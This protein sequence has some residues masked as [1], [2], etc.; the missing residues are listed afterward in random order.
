MIERPL[1]RDLT[2]IELR[3][4]ALHRQTEVKLAALA[5]AGALGDAGI[6][7]NVLK[8]MSD[9]DLR[10]RVLGGRHDQR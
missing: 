1:G 7:P 8:A 10:E 9:P 3:E 4:L 6:L 5:L 2:Q